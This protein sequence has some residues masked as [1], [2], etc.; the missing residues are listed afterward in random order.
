VAEPDRTESYLRAILDRVDAWLRFAE[1]KNGGMIALSATVTTA[2]LATLRNMDD[3]SVAVRVLFTLAIVLFLLSMSVALFSY[4]PRMQPEKL[5]G[6][7]AAEPGEADNLYFYGDLAKYTPAGLTEAVARRYAGDGAYDAAR[8][9]AHLHLAHQ[10][11][12][13]SRITARKLRL[14]NA[15]GALALG[16]ALV[17][18]V[19]LVVRLLGM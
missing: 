3:L 8:Y 17:Y 7:A 5:A 10:A 18:A 13:N 11:T 1:V 2:L 12:I 19:A 14:F 6:G 15:G 4:L 16:G 9:P